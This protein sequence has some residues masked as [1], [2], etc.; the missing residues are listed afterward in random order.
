[1]F[2]KSFEYKAKS[3]ILGVRKSF[4]GYAWICVREKGICINVF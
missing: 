4:G 2:D 3:L 1:M